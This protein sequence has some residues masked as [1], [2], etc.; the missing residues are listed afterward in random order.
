MAAAGLFPSCAN[1][2]SSSAAAV[3]FFGERVEA[4]AEVT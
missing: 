3:P 4:S 2:V 1:G